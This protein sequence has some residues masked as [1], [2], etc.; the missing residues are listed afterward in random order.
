MDVRVYLWEGKNVALTR[1]T[2]RSQL[3]ANHS[4]SNNKPPCRSKTIIDYYGL[5]KD[6]YSNEQY[7]VEFGLNKEV[8]TLKILKHKDYRGPEP[9]LMRQDFGRGRAFRDAFVDRVMAT[10]EIERYRYNMYWGEF[11]RKWTS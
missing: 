6:I 7:F 9:T 8:S 11:T 10:R 1:Q 4:K 2:S 5:H 3:Y